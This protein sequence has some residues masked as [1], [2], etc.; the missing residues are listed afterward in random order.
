MD[1]K[2]FVTNVTSV[3]GFS[4]R[5]RWIWHS[6]LQWVLQ[7]SA[8]AQTRGPSQRY[9]IQQWIHRRNKWVSK[10]QSTSARLISQQWFIM[11]NTYLLSMTFSVPNL[12]SGHLIIDRRQWGASDIK[13][14]SHNIPLPHPIRYVII[15]HIG[16]QSRP[17]DN[18]Y[19][20]SIKMRTIQDS[21]IAERGLSDLSANF[22]VS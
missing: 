8:E 18:V 19:S 20:C 17:C 3:C 5:L 2:H 1:K 16:M 12:G 11:N 7:I 21:A 9:F 6:Y 15:T 14:A 22:Y 13:D 4:S 10:H